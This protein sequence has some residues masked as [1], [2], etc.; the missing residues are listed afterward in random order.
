MDYPKITITTRF[1]L[2][3]RQSVKR[4]ENLVPEAH[5]GIGRLN[6]KTTTEKLLVTPFSYFTFCLAGPLFLIGWTHHF[7]AAL[8]TR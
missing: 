5:K 4:R 1:P 2:Q 8:S 7:T 3:I 6:T